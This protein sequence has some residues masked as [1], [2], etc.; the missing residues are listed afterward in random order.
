MFKRQ[1]KSIKSTLSPRRSPA[2]KKGGNNPSVIKFLWCNLTFTNEP[3]WYRL[4]VIVI[5]LIATLFIIWALKEWTAPALVIG[6][7]LH[8]R[9]ATLSDFLKSIFRR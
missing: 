6:K 9:F 3:L 1:P 7:T 2:N 8:H 5:I 4:I